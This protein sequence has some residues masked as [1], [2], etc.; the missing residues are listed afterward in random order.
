MLTL[1]LC[2]SAAVMAGV[3]L[4]EVDCSYDHG[5]EENLIFVPSEDGKHHSIK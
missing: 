4:M 5:A 3:Q 1:A 2:L